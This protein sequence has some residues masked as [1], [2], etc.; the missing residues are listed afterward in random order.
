MK[1]IIALWSG[2]AASIP[3][4]WTL[5]NGTLGTPD[6]RNKF[7]IGAGST[8]A[9]GAN[10]AVS[11]HTHTANLGSHAHDLVAGVNITAGYDISHI[12]ATALVTGTTAANGNLPPYYALCYIMHI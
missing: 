10:S 9:P 6:L 3:F 5:C 4:G 2:S 1:G 12:T 7:I 11:T 8:Y